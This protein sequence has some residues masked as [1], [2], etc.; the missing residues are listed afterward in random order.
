MSV[1]MQCRSE[2]SGPPPP[3]EAV[4]QESRGVPAAQVPTPQ[5]QT[6]QAWSRALSGS[7]LHP[8]TRHMPKQVASNIAAAQERM[9]MRP[10]RPPAQ[11]EVTSSRRAMPPPAAVVSV[12]TDPKAVMPVQQPRPPSLFA[13]D[14]GAMHPHGRLWDVLSL[15]GLRTG[16]MPESGVRQIHGAAL[17]AGLGSG[18]TSGALQQRPGEAIMPH[19]P[20]GHR[21]QGGR[22]GVPPARPVQSLMPPPPPVITIASP[23]GVEDMAMIVSGQARGVVDSGPGGSSGQPGTSRRF[24]RRPNSFLD[25]QVAM[26]A[27]ARAAAEAER[28]AIAA[29]RAHQRASYLAEQNALD[30]RM[31]ARLGVPREQDPRLIYQANRIEHDMREEAGESEAPLPLKDP[32]NQL[33]IDMA[34]YQI[35]H[36]G[37]PPSMLPQERR[38]PELTDANISR[39]IHDLQHEMDTRHLEAEESRAGETGAHSEAAGGGHVASS[40]AGP[41]GPGTSHDQD[42][43]D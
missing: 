41:S 24:V 40:G 11:P 22:A 43:L 21:L 18:T 10:A 20:A 8:F 26:N 17:Q 36:T 15:Q 1:H 32:G 38:D 19:A 13:A 4:S 42:T 23:P 5:Q 33:V 2:V 7:A 29:A 30:A 12:H 3:V 16:I 28:Q 6:M 39:I 25:A 14:T 9:A 37:L 34:R 27:H 31:A 35:V